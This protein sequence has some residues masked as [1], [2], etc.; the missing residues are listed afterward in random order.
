MKVV[1]RVLVLLALLLF[2][3]WLLRPSGPAVSQGSI[4]VIELS[5]EYVETAEPS[6]FVR[7]LGG[8]QRPFASLLS[9]LEKAR[10]DDRLAGVVLRV[11]H[12]G[13]DWGMAQELREA[14]AELRAAGRPT[15]AFLETGALGANLEYYV[16]SAADRV[17]VSPGSSSPLVGLAMEFVFLGGMWEKLG[18]GFEAIGSG[19]YKSAAET[20]AGKEMSEPHREM[21]TWLLD[22]LW[23]QFVGGIASDRKLDE[24]SVRDA[25][26]GAPTS[27]QELV[28]AGLAD[29][30]A[31]FDEAVEMLGSGDRIDGEDYRAVDPKSVGFDPRARFALVYGSGA[32]TLGR[33]SVAPSGAPVLA[34]DTVAEAIE[35][36]AEDTDVDA[37]VL[38]VDSPGGSP[39]ASEIVWRATQK[40]RA[41]GKPVVASVSNVAAS[42]GYY[43]LCGADAVVASPASLVGSIGVFAVR[44]VVAGLLD[45]LGIGY[46]SMTRGT[47]ADL[48]LATQ[49]LS[50]AGRE[51]MLADIDGIYDLFVKRVASGRDL[52]PEAVDA[53]GRGRVFTGEQALARG[54]VTELGGL[55]VAVRRAK[56]LV[57]LDPATDV[58]LVTYPPPRSLAQQIS[59]ALREA[60]IAARPRLPLP[61]ILQQLEA[62]S[63]VLPEGAPLLVPPVLVEVH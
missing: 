23:A 56:V 17:I 25:I 15:L 10:R 48:L 5:G 20:I 7:L 38:R 19:A 60:S 52:T 40:A 16:A 29:G 3:A 37:I 32:V 26:D 2:A 46:A 58:E 34:S 63:D 28:A 53:V 61:G 18:A 36:A 6:F 57:G 24:A 35:Q 33:G 31:S 45:K 27:P 41:A 1:R 11:R 21:A 47:H 39:L 62:L 59:D 43:V 12:L 22:S 50:P 4:L 9:E 8:R 30:V 14:L 55:R 49:P 54:L 51:R 13:D 42:G 44:P